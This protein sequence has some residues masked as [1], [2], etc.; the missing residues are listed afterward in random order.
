[1]KW[2]DEFLQQYI[3]DEEQ[4]AQAVEQFSKEV[5]PKHAVPKDRFNQTSE[6]LKLT[7]EQLDQQTKTIE[8]LD[9]KAKTADEYAEKIEQLKEQYKQIE[10]QSQEQISQITKKM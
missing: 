1:M 3:E 4:R 10:Q 5:F 7:K 6:E 9:S 8:E 2:I